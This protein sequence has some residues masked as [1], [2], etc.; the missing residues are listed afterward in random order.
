MIATAAAPYTLYAWHLSYYA[1]KTRTY[2]TYKKVP[3]VEVPV[4]YRLLMGPVKRHTGASVMP[5]MTTPDGRWLQD[6]RHIIDTLEP[7]YPTPPIL[8]STPRRRIA[9]ELIE[10]WGDEWWIPIA[11]HTRWT[12]GENYALFEREA[13]DALAPWAPR[14]V[15]DYLVS[16]V[17]RLLRGY[18]PQVG[19]IPSQYAMMEAWSL[20]MLDL[21]DRHLAAV[22][23]VLGGH[24]T[25]A[26]FGLVSTMYGHL[27]RDP[28]PKRVWI[29]P[30]PHLRGWIDRMAELDH[31]AVR[32]R[33]GAPT[34][35]APDDAL[36]PTLEPV[37]RTICREFLP[38]VQAILDETQRAITARPDRTRPLPRSLGTVGFPMGGHTFTRRAMPF[39][40]WKMQ[41]VLD[42][43]RAMPE[44]DRATVRGWLRGLGGE[45]FLDLDIPRLERVALQVQ[46]AERT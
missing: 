13:G 24:P 45:G 39:T 17:A 15:K 1:G 28:W 32:A 31:D 34:P 40:L 43:F 36:P 10:A 14:F 26:D 44:P 46:L 12:Y 21:L 35:D 27:G 3:F 7:L 6:T 11:M 33:Y 23:Y 16:R 5:T 8:P 29:D 4:S 18:A 38:M 9:A 25:L 2:L 19:I 42:A 20:T 37:L 41:G 22:P 30:R